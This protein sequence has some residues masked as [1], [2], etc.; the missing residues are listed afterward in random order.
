MHIRYAGLFYISPPARSFCA[1]GGDA[2]SRLSDAYFL[3][4]L[5]PTVFKPQAIL[6]SLLT[7]RLARRINPVGSLSD[8]FSLNE[9][10]FFEDIIRK[11]AIKVEK[12]TFITIFA[13]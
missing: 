5:F 3:M 13:L 6:K 2:V 11:N 4:L 7:D 8:N 12:S 10:L 9:R 1:G